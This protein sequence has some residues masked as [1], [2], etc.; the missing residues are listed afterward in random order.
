MIQSTTPSSSSTY[1]QSNSSQ[2]DASSPPHFISMI[3]SDGTHNP[4]Y[5]S[6]STSASRSPLDALDSTAQQYRTSTAFNPAFSTNP[7]P[8]SA[9]SAAAYNAL[10]PSPNPSSQSQQLQLQQ[11]QQQQPQQQQPQQRSYRSELSA[12]SPFPAHYASAQPNYPTKADVFGTSQSLDSLSRFDYS[13]DSFGDPAI[14]SAQPHAHTQPH[15]GVKQAYNGTFGIAGQ[16][17]NTGSALLQSQQVQVS[18][19]AQQGHAQAQTQQTQTQQQAQQQQQQGYLNS[20]PMMNGAVPYM[21]GHGQGP[22]HHHGMQTN[23]IGYG[24]PAHAQGST[25]HPMHH[26]PGPG[27][28]SGSAQGVVMQQSQPPQTQ[29]QQQNARGDQAQE[30]ISTIFVVGFPEDMHEREFQNMFT[31][32]LGFEAATLKIPNKDSSAYGP[33]AG[34]PGAASTLRQA[35]FLPS[36]SYPANA[37]TQAGTGPYSGAQDPYNLVTVNSGGV[38]VDGPQGTSS[39]WQQPGSSDQ[40]PNE[41]SH[42][43]PPTLPPRKQIIGF[44]KFR[45]RQEALDARDILQGRRVDIEKG[46]VLKAEMAKKNLHTK[47]G[48]GPLLPLGLMGAGG[49]VIGPEMLAGVSGLNGY[50]GAS[51]PTPAPAAQVQAGSG[52]GGDQLSARERELG[53]LG[54]MGLG[55]MAR[56]QETREEEKERRDMAQAQVQRP[57]E[58]EERRRK[59]KDLER[60]RN[61]KLRMSN[62]TVYD[63]FHS[64]PGP[65]AGSTSVN[66]TGASQ[67]AL[68][69]PGPGYA[70]PS[71]AFPGYG[72][73]SNGGGSGFQISGHGSNSNGG[74]GSGGNSGTFATSQF[75]NAAFST[76]DAYAPGSTNS[77]SASTPGGG[78]SAWGLPTKPS[79][80][81]TATQKT[82]APPAS[83]PPRPPSSLQSSPPANFDAPAPFLPSGTQAPRAFYG[84]DSSTFSPNEYSAPLPPIGPRPRVQSPAFEGQQYGATAASLPPSSSSSVAGSQSSLEGEFSRTLT[85]STHQGMT[86][87]QLP[88]PGSGGSSNNARQGN[89]SDQNPPINTLYVGNL[90]NSPAPTGYPPN[91][92]EESLRALFSRCAGYR[93]LC[94]RQK[95]NGPMC[96]VEFDDVSYATKALSD[97]YGNQLNGFVKGGIRLS[98]S[99]N[100]LGVRPT[101]SS[102]ANSHQGARRDGAREWNGH[103]QQAQAQAPGMSYN[104]HDAFQARALQSQQQHQQG[105]SLDIGSGRQQMRHEQSEM[106][107]P[108]P[109]YNYSVSP[110]PSRFFSPPPSSSQSSFGAMG[111]S[112]SNAFPRSTTQS[113]F[114]QPSAG[115][116]SAQHS[117]PYFPDGDDRMRFRDPPPHGFVPSPGLETTARVG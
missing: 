81:N 9:S 90:P 8:F 67:S 41:P 114:G 65:R 21:N 35:G 96:F 86:S 92:L 39:S 111:S 58:E 18:K 74:G 62:T 34:T 113:S 89:A 69:A 91:Y 68:A 49:G 36:A 16:P 94:F 30:E 108:N 48:V 110:P 98:F 25:Q 105:L 77:T 82:P 55:G 23:G 93:K 46:A 57:R 11:Q 80:T 5:H 84:S 64:V 15:L 51:A 6:S 109:I 115:F 100:P 101:P 71:S 47:R 2:Q 29:Q 54:A 20:P 112:A 19:L 42:A 53:V 104:I 79:D 27:P 103:A 10:G 22:L 38:V 117:P 99:K 56:R 61:N 32:S 50:M 78:S 7:G 59:E 88:S 14:N 13:S 52:S 37:H 87:P 12:S 31:F 73:Q 102:T 1:S 60:E 33:A 75:Q 97:L 106:G 116:A 95:S 40:Y 44:A 63:A 28:G 72:F 107:S 17:T 26:A 70:D 3:P 85:V 45:S 43:Q 83:L 66:G 76:Q 24:G 4:M